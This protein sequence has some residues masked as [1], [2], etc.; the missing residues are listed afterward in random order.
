[1]NQ[2][3]FGLLSGIILSSYLTDFV[4]NHLK[5]RRSR[6]FT[7]LRQRGMKERQPRIKFA[8]MHRVVPSS[9]PPF[10]SF[11]MLLLAAVLCCSPSWAQENSGW[12]RSLFQGTQKSMCDSSA[13]R[14]A[15]DG[16]SEAPGVLLWESQPEAPEA[17]GAAGT[18]ER[19][20]STE[21]RPLGSLTQTCD[22]RIL[23]L[24]SAWHEEEHVLRGFRI[25][26]YAGSLQSAREIRAKLRS[27][28]HDWPVYL[29]SMPPNYRVT[30]GDF[31][32]RWEA[33]KVQDEWRESFPMSIVIPM[34]INLPSLQ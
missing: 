20:E 12:W 11:S 24:D 31:R 33:L 1:M 25:Q 26:V 8:R 23:S 6:N 17:S 21:E 4:R 19:N 28:P 32:T 13:I 29:S 5:L 10:G 16:A 34:D 22:E 2:S 7:F 30:L 14:P 18:G 27:L 3:L 9:V 15:A